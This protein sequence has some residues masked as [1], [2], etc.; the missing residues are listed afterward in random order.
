ML[1][2]HHATRKGVLSFFRPDKSEPPED[3]NVILTLPRE[4]TMCAGWRELTPDGHHYC[5]NPGRSNTV[6]TVTGLWTVQTLEEDLLHKTMCYLR[7]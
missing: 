4:E 7:R 5:N 6:T 1:S 3:N 2:Y